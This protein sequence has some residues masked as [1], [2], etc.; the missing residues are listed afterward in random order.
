MLEVSFEARIV[1]DSWD[2]GE[3]VSKDVFAFISKRGDNLAWCRVYVDIFGETETAAAVKIGEMMFY[4]YNASRCDLNLDAE[5]F[6]YLDP[7]ETLFALMDDESEDLMHY[8]YDFGTLYEHI[9]PYDTEPLFFTEDLHIIALHRLFIEPEYRGLGIGRFIVN[10]LSK[11][12]FATS[13]I[14]PVYVVGCISPDDKTEAT[15]AIQ[16]K[17]MESANYA[18]LEDEEGHC[19]FGKCIFDEDII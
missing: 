14:K 16:K 11:I 12:I 5:E 4:A 3:E 17:T 8:Y 19:I 15:K 9:K 18:I 2:G 6:E 10:N 7:E 1:R 13:N